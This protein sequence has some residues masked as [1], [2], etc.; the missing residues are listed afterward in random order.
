[1]FESLINTFMEYY[2]L[3]EKKA[4]VSREKKISVFAQCNVKKKKRKKKKRQTDEQK[5]Q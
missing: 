1:M 3:N 4:K 5:K 2:H